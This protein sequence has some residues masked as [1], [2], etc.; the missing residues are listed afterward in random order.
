MSDSDDKPFVD[1]IG[2]IVG[3]LDR[4]VAQYGEMLGV[5]PS[6]VRE[7]PE[8][9]VRV[10]MIETAN[11]TLELIQH[12]GGEDAFARRVNGSREGINHISLRV[13]DLERS[14][15][16]MTAAGAKPMSGFPIKGVHGK[17][18]FFEP[19]STAGLLL[20]ICEHD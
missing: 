9:G 15:A 6:E 13:D 14:A 2:I 17:V 12:T 3:D 19:A 11:V 8:V 1:H 4:A 10:A 5:E 16:I 7:M 20:E 18:L